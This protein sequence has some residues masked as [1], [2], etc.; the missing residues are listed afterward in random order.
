MV[1]D[2]TECHGVSC[3]VYRCPAARR[4]GTSHP[5]DRAAHNDQVVGRDEGERVSCNK[6]GKASAVSLLA[7]VAGSTLADEF[8]MTRGATEIS[9]SIFD[10]HMLIFWICMVVGVGVFSALLWSVIWHRKS[11]GAVPAQFHSSTRLEILWTSL[12]LLILIAMAFPATTTLVAMYDIGG[13]DMAVEVRGYQ[14]KWQYK[15]LDDDYNTTF[16][17]F[18]NL[19]T[20]AE[21]IRNRSV[22]TENYLIE[23]DEPLRIPVNRKVRF[24]I[25]SEDVIHAWWVPDFGIKRDAIP[26]FL[27]RLVDH[28]RAA[29][30]LSGSMHGALWY[31]P[32]LHAHRGRGYGAGRFYSVVRGQGASRPGARRGVSQEL[33]AR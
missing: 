23:V 11:R 12:P 20:P 8:N 16:G 19:A 14:W 7:V 31:G 21:Q 25:T 32:R 17:F 28:C 27:E 9:R 15:Y 22:K 10:L 1:V 29:G 3:R 24:L 30:H 13:E 4:W 5:A 18:S 2:E 6:I 26:G 33:Y